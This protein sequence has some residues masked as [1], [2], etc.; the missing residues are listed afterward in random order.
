MAIAGAVW[1]SV[2][3][4]SLA[5][6]PVTGVLF[7]DV[8]AKVKK[9]GAVVLSTKTLVTG[10]WVELGFGL[11]MIKW[12]AADMD[13]LG[14]FFFRLSG[15]LFDTQSKSFDVDPAS[16]ASFVPADVCVIMG[17]IRDLGG[18]PAMM[19]D[20]IIRGSDFPAQSGISLVTSDIIRFR[21][22]F[23]GNFTVPVLRLQKVIFEIEKT[24]IRNEITVP[25]LPTA[26]LLDLLPPI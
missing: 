24:G 26:N 25:N 10:D 7:S 14:P 1:E 23:Y 8:T 13:T 4:L 12:S 6:A 16:F 21:P 5:G 15:V 9:A 22:D 17:N 18:N 19:S 3:Y 2:V 20:I 11:Y